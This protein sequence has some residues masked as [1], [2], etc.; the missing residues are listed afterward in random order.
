MENICACTLYDASTMNP[1]QNS[2]KEKK[3]Q[4]RKR[5]YVLRQILDIWC[6][7]FEYRNAFIVIVFNL[8]WIIPEY[9]PV[10]SEAKTNGGKEINNSKCTQKENWKDLGRCYRSASLQFSFRASGTVYSVILLYVVKLMWNEEQ[11][12][13]LPKCR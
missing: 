9:L 2:N 7:I 12:G 1:Q 3:Q 8:A 13:T 4:N 6:L 5:L 10:N 11:P